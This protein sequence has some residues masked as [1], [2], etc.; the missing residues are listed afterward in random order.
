[1]C[2]TNAPACEM[3]ATHCVVCGRPLV[4]AESVE[5][6]VGPDCRANSGLETGIA[7]ATRTA[8]NRLTHE[9]AVAA[10]GR[11]GSRD[12]ARDLERAA[13]WLRQRVRGNIEAKKRRLLRDRS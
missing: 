9:A 3:L 5:C 12:R 7:D 2:Y 11:V 13:A 4:D 10:G 8:A 6:G 1:M